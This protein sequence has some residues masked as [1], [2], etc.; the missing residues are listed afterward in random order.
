VEEETDRLGEMINETTDMARIESGKP[1]IRRRQ[2]SVS[3]LI[4]SSLHRMKTLLD[5]RPL[6]VKIQE[7]ISNV[8]ADPDMIG[9]ALRQ[10]LGNAV[11]YSPPETMIAISASQIEDT[12]TVSIRDYGPGIPSDEVE[13]VFQR[14]YRGKQTQES[15]AGTG[16]GLSIAR[17]I[18]GAHHGKLRLQNT[19]E[20]GAQFSF[21]LHAF[22]EVQLS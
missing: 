8:D 13:A 18:V 15:V 19:P 7:D 22:H 3:D 16:M 17:D 1:Q 12:I 20:G 14:F 10:L 6:E 2:V 11:K 9:L 5:G 21:T 4:G